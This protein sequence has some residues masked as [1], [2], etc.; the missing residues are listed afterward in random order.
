M[1]SFSIQIRENLDM[2][3]ENGYH[4]QVLEWEPNRLLNEMVDEGALSASIDDNHNLKNNMLMVI[5]NW[6]I[7]KR[8]SLTV[9][10]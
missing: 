5:T 10:N 1:R 7:A 9:S 4:S 2:A 8:Q 6:K 3:W